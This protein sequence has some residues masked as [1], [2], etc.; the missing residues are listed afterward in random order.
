MKDNERE[1]TMF[2]DSMYEYA[3]GADISHYEWTPCGDAPPVLASEFNPAD[4]ADVVIDYDAPIEHKG[5]TYIPIC[6]GE[7]EPSAILETA[8]DEVCWV[9]YIPGNREG[10]YVSDGTVYPTEKA[11]MQG[12]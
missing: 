6:W 9:R 7:N 1:Q 11:A 10:T 2:Y 4:D 12:R 3:K 5:K 8:I